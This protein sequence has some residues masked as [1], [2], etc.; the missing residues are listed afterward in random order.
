MNWKSVIL[1][2]CVHVH[3]IPDFLNLALSITV[4]DNKKSPDSNSSTVTLL[5]QIHSS[6][7]YTTTVVRYDNRITVQYSTVQHTTVVQYST[8]QHT[9]VV[10]YSTSIINYC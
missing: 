8:V 7:V 3:Q 1:C 5:C 10:Q 6:T 4:V 2:T 9:T